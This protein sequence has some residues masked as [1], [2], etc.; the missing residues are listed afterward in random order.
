ML[1]MGGI[2]ARTCPAK[3]RECLEEPEQMELSCIS[4]GQCGAE[5]SAQ[6]EL[7][8]WSGSGFGD[9]VSPTFSPGHLHSYKME[10]KGSSEDV[11]LLPDFFSSFSLHSSFCQR[12]PGSIGMSC[13]A[14]LLTLVSDYQG[15]RCLPL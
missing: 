9:G 2:G 5:H 8:V 1:G 4:L 13:H 15:V 7:Q 12:S 14:L 10:E 11:G 3:Q 6:R